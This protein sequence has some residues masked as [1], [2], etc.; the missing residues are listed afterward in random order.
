MGRFQ[1]VLYSGDA[2]SSANIA[3]LCNTHLFL[4]ISQ[5]QCIMN[6]RVPSAVCL[7]WFRH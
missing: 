5:L 6:M 3:E 2:R 4:H 7:P 1:N